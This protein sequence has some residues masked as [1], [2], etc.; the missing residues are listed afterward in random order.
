M[1]D[2][3]VKLRD[4]VFAHNDATDARTVVVFPPGSWSP[5]GSA[6]EEQTTLLIDA[7]PLVETLCNFQ[8]DRIHPRVQ[9][10]VASVCEGQQ[11]GDGAII[12]LSD[13]PD[14]P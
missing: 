11:Y 14:G 13:I 7:I 4:T 12:Y 1:H 9:E 8:I 10:L 5:E 3:L 2:Q 6:T